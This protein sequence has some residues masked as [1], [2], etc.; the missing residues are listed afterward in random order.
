MPLPNAAPDTPGGW[1]GRGGYRALQAALATHTSRFVVL[2]HAN[3]E[4]RWIGHF[5]CATKED[6]TRIPVVCTVCGDRAEHARLT[7]FI[8]SACSAACSCTSRPLF[9]DDAGRRKIVALADGA[10]A[11]LTISEKDW[12]RKHLARSSLWKRISLRCRHCRAT[13]HVSTAGILHKTRL[14]PCACQK[15]KSPRRAK[16]PTKP[17]PGSTT[18]KAVAVAVVVTPARSLAICNSDSE[19]DE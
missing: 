12:V 11:D 17:A 3:S 15:K 6:A 16:A 5:L 19:N 4:I 8:A 2:P 9:C 13:R 18:P 7:N 10:Q 1:R 14:A